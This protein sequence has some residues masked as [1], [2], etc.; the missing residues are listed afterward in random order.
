VVR[1]FFDVTILSFE[2]GAMKPDPRIYDEAA[3]RAGVRPAEIFFTDDRQENVTAACEAGFD[4]VQFEE[5]RQLA[6]E[7][8]RRGV[9]WNY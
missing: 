6:A 7:L 5:T 8:R 3:R 1:Y 2:V 9:R 4:A